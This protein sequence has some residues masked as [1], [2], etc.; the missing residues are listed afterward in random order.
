MGYA[1]IDH[2]ILTDP[3]TEDLSDSAFALFVKLVTWSSRE[4]SDGVV[5]ART[6]RKLGSARALRELVTVGLITADERNVVVK[7]Y[8]KHNTS[9]AEIAAKRDGAKERA[10]H[11]RERRAA[12]PS[13]ENR[14]QRTEY[15]DLES[16]KG[17]SPPVRAKQ[18][19]PKKKKWTIVPETWEPQQAH[20]DKA[21]RLRLPFDKELSKFRLWEFKD[22]KADANRAF[23]R[24]LDTAAER[25]AERPPGPQ[26]GRG[27]APQTPHLTE[28]ERR[29]N[30]EIEELMKGH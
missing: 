12:H 2:R 10:A 17:A 6:R 20:R 22:P 25:A 19:L 11:S 16:I 3:R 8:L 15:R 7:N 29:Q 28:R 5:P 23:H 9:Q 13:T 18:R 27:F 1:K 26:Q 14:V 24:W 30:A 21:H 4:E